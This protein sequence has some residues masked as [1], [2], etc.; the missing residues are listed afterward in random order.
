MKKHWQILE[1]DIHS[2]EQVRSV[3]NCSIV[4][5]SVLVNRNIVSA[6]D[7]IL[8][9]NSSLKNIRPPFSIKDMD[10]AVRRIYT[11]ITNHEKILIFGDYDVDGITATTIVMSE[12]MYHTIYPTGQKRDTV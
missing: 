3:L 4:T 10:A 7:A 12:Q 5:A 9:L 8:F 6:Y 1:P 2:V 11:A